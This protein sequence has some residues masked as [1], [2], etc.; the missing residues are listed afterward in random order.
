MFQKNL[1]NQGPERWRRLD[2]RTSWL[3]NK[4]P[5][6]DLGVEETGDALEELAVDSD[7]VKLA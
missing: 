7:E 5:S 1:L 3:K 2:T 6:D 4:N